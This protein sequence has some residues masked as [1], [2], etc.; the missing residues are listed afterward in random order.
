MLYGI[1][2]AF[3]SLQP[4]SPWVPPDPATP[5]WPFAPGTPL[6]FTR[7]DIVAN[8]VAYVPFGFFVALW[9]GA[10]PP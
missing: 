10:L 8:V 3:A 6:R 1:A 4:F 9:R 2:I 7:Y 5:F